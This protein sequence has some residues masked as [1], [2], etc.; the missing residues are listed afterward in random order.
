MQMQGWSWLETK[1]RCEVT[2]VHSL[3]EQGQLV[4]YGRVDGSQN[5]LA[6]IPRSFWPELDIFDEHSSCVI[7]RQ[8]K[9]EISDIRIFPILLAPDATELLHD[10]GLAE[11][12]MALIVKD[13]EV[14]VLG[15]RVMASDGHREVF[16]DGNAPGPII[17]SHWVL[18]GDA[19]SLAYEFVRPYIFLDDSPR[20]P[21]VSVVAAATALAE[22]MAALKLLL[23]TGRLNAIGTHRTSGTLSSI[24]RAQWLRADQAIDI[25]NG[26]L[27]ERDHSKWVAVW[28]GIILESPKGAG[29]V[30][31]GSRFLERIEGFTTPKPSRSS[32]AAVTQ[33]ESWLVRLVREH[34]AGRA[35]SKSQLFEEAT[36]RW[37]DLSRRGFERAWSSATA[38]E[39]AAAWRTGGRPR[40]TSAPETS[41]PK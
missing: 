19:K 32:I 15:R 24:H 22:R 17:D 11:V 8:S 20:R 31:A 4:A 9:V 38:D 30:S 10:R 14:A 7:H 6:L 16:L 25:I 34:P 40:K 26:D 18:D 41:T 1:E 21:S 3:F 37:P 13:P 5:D 2:E 39:E 28:T 35:N 27:C 33:C 12:F 29:S 23:S 36:Q